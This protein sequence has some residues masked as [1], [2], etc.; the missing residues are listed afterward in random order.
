L[1]TLHSAGKDACNVGDEGGFAP[2]IGDNEEGLKLLTGA[3][4]KAGYTGKVSAGAR[5]QKL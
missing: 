2:S 1:I 4:E 5:Q 3:I